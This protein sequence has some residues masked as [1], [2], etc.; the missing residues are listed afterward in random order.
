M[1]K[2]INVHKNKEK[3]HKFVLTQGKN[4]HFV[5]ENMPASSQFFWPPCK[6]LGQKNR[7]NENNKSLETVPL[8][9]LT[10]LAMAI[11]GG[12]WRTAYIST[13]N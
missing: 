13:P 12:Y 4:L 7:K 10:L 2:K 9:N 3:L 1:T 8:I 11:A 5:M 6:E